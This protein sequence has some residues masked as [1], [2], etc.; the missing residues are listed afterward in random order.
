MSEEIANIIQKQT[1]GEKVSGLFQWYATAMAF[2]FVF[3]SLP[4][5]IWWQSEG[6][7][8][9]YLLFGFLGWIVIAWIVFCFMLVSMLL[10]APE[11]I[12]FLE[13]GAGSGGADDGV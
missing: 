9:I 13:R 5:G 7:K 1:V 11:K 3:G 8:P 4:A 10:N 2:T 6:A 12:S